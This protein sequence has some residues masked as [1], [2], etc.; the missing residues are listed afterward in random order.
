MDI[1]KTILTIT[2]IG[3]V[4]I[5]GNYFIDEAQINSFK[6]DFELVGGSET[7]SRDISEYFQGKKDYVTWQEMTEWVRV[8][9]TMEV[10][11]FG[12]IESKQDFIKKI[13]YAITEKAK[14]ER[15]IIGIEKPLDIESGFIDPLI[16]I[17]LAIVGVLV[18]LIPI[19]K[20]K[21]LIVVGLLVIGFII[22][23]IIKKNKQ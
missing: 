23:L 6:A 10:K 8:A 13:N 3:L 1:K 7:M 18:A 22:Y 12:K 20:W 5:S 21:V 2:T 15:D 14:I 16:A 11:N 4:G 19:L 9:N 17:S